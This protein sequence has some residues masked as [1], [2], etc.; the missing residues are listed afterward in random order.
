MRLLGF[1]QRLEPVGDFRETFLARRLRHPRIHI[2]VFVGLTVNRGLEIEQRVADRQ[3]GGR[4]AYLLQVI[5][6]PMGMAGFA[7]GGITKQTCDFGLPFDI[8]DLGEIE[9]AS[10]GLALA[11]KRFF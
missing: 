8:R 9:I 7:F 5:E 3:I 4:I 10:I 6:M 11:G 1:R 2:G